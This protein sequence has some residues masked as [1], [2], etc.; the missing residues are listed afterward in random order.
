MIEY[1]QMFLTLLL[2]PVLATSCVWYKIDYKIE[3]HLKNN[4]VIYKIA[5]FGVFFLL[6]KIYIE[7]VIKFIFYK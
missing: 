5:T 7:M 6:A 4:V 2:I 1:I 3:E